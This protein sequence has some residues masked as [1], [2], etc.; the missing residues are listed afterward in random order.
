MWF[1][2]NF[3]TTF[4]GRFKYILF[5]HFRGLKEKPRLSPLKYFINFSLILPVVL[6]FY[7]MAYFTR[8]LVLLKNGFTLV[9]KES[10]RYCYSRLRLSCLHIMLYTCTQNENLHINKK[11]CIYD[12]EACTELLI[13]WIFFFFKSYFSS[14]LYFI[15]FAYAISINVSPFKE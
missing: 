11:K 3:L 12:C 6:L 14:Q 1:I 15:R 10:K 5:Y 9:R 7:I 4:L 8:V 13:F 2:I